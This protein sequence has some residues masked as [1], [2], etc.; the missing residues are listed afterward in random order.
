MQAIE[1]AK[2]L[3]SDKV[4]EVRSDGTIWKLRNLNR[5]PLAGPRR[6]ETRIKSGYLAVRINHRGSAYLLLAHRLV[7]EALRGPI[8]AGMTVNHLDGCK[9]NNHPENLE[10]V[11]Q[12]DNNKHAY[13]MLGRT[14]PPQIPCPV[15]DL[16]RDQAIALRRQGL[17]YAEIAARLGISQTTAF[18]AARAK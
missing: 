7:W 9:T 6:L 13:R 10:V 16:V 12:S 3:I 4:I 2:R 15:L 17:P 8:P 5:M 14:A 1:V 18:R 11:T